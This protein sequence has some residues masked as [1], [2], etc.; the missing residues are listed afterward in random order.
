VTSN[1]IK[2]RWGRAV[3]FTT[4][5]VALTAALAQPVG[6][7][8]PPG[9]PGEGPP[10]PPCIANTRVNSMSVNQRSTFGVSTVRFSWD[11]TKGC[12]GMALSVDGQPVAAKGSI[13][14]SVATTRR[15]TVRGQFGNGSATFYGPWVLAGRF[16]VYSSQNGSL[17]PGQ[18]RASSGNADVDAGA[19]RLTEA[20]RTAQLDNFAG[21][22]VD[23][24]VFPGSHNINE[25]PPWDEEPAENFANFCGKARSDEDGPDRYSIAVRINPNTGCIPRKTVTHEL[26][27]AVLAHVD[28]DIREEATQAHATRAFATLLAIFLELDLPPWVGCDDTYSASTVH[29]YW[30]EGTAALFDTTSSCGGEY[31]PDFLAETDSPLDHALRRAFDV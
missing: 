1:P 2:Q 28:A 4:A 15:L 12:G 10:V 5:L 21:K 30:A 8:P 25:L 20:L 19:R 22:R 7:I 13:N 6:A 31:T 26:G 29:E 16:V 14:V 24:H 17:G 23:V 27:H 3:A 11:I 18:V 9:D